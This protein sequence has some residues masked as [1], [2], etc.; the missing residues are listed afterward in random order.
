MMLQ[1][2]GLI[3]KILEATN[4]QD[5]SLNW[6]PTS[7]EVGPTT[8]G[9][10]SG[11]HQSSFSRCPG[12]S[13]SHASGQI[14]E[15]QQPVPLT[16]TLHP[17]ALQ[18]SWLQRFLSPHAKGKDAQ[19][20]CEAHLDSFNRSGSAFGPHPSPFGSAFFMKDAFELFISALR[21][22]SEPIQN[23]AT[24]R[25][26]WTALHWFL[27]SAKLTSAVFPAQGLSH[28]DFAS[29]LL[30]I[31]FFICLMTL[32]PPLW[33]LHSFSGK[34]ILGTIFIMVL[35]CLVKQLEDPTIKATWAAQWH[36]LTLQWIEGHSHTMSM[37]AEVVPNNPQQGTLCLLN[38]V[39][40][41]SPHAPQHQQA[42]Q[43]WSTSAME[44]LGRRFPNDVVMHPSSLIHEFLF[45]SCLNGASHF[46][47]QSGMVASGAGCEFGRDES[48]GR[49]SS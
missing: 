4:V 3:N 32:P 5:C 19:H 37:I 15:L 42:C 1:T 12:V 2:T 25:K 6:T 41:A 30:S 16:W 26:A 35:D 7:V 22:L 34:N 21:W 24:V 48:C 49:A 11:L 18:S 36:S 45:T 38:P 29:A 47:F 23:D 33:S 27:S 44:R 17:A 14:L 13:S 10:F 31:K 9:A 8:A 39:M 43:S 28:E 20:C 40:S 46:R